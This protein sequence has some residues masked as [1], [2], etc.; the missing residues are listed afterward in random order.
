MTLARV[1]SSECL[2]REYLW[3]DETRDSSEGSS[4]FCFTAWL[5]DLSK[6]GFTLHAHRLSSLLRKF[7]MPRLTLIYRKQFHLATNTLRGC[8]GAKPPL[9]QSKR[10]AQ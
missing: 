2:R 9:F 5:S 6:R 7:R 3:Q 8:G 10:N 1:D 4:P